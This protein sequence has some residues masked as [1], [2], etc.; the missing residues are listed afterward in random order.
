MIWFP[1]DHPNSP[2]YMRDNY[3]EHCIECGERFEEYCMGMYTGICYM[4]E[5]KIKNKENQD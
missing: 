4:C 1:E 2:D 3:C 5:Q